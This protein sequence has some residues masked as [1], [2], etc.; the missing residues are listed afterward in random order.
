[1]LAPRDV[2]WIYDR[3]PSRQR[4]GLVVDG[5]A[6]EFVAL[7]EASDLEHAWIRHLCGLFREFDFVFP[8]A[9]GLAQGGKL[10]DAAQGRLVEGGP[11]HRAHAPHVDCS[12]LLLEA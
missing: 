7:T 4:A 10:I 5:V 8:G 1:M 12:A 2:G 9:V 3:D 6:R 11:Q